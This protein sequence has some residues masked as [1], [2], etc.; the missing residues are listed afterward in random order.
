MNVK[1]PDHV[2]LKARDLVLKLLRKNS[3]DRLPLKEV[4]KHPWIEE[5]AD[6]S[7]EYYKYW[8]EIN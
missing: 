3:N 8:K 4:R 6:K 5:F 2:N 7:E 1:F